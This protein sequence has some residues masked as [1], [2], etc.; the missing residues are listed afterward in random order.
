MVK[1]EGQGEGEERREVVF[2][3][4]EGHLERHTGNAS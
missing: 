4:R 3:V 2:E 1:T